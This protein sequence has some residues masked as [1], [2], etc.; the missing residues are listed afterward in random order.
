MWKHRECKSPEKLTGLPNAGANRIIRYE[1]AS[2]RRSAGIAMTTT[3]IPGTGR[4]LI[5]ALTAAVIGLA[6]AI[7][8]F[9]P[10]AAQQGSSIPAPIVIPGSQGKETST[11]EL[12]SMRSEERRVGKEG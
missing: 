3:T 1:R 11:L 7:G 10:A 6:I 2:L 4:S 12:P 9:A 8:G 5:S